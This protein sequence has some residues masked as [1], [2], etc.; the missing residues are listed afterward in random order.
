MQGDQVSVHLFPCKHV[1]TSIQSFTCSHT[2]V[3]PYSHASVPIH[4]ISIHPQSCTFS[5]TYDIYSQSCICS[6]TCVYLYSH[7][8]VPIKI[9][10]PIVMHLFPYIC[11]PIQSC[12]YSHASIHPYS[13]L[14]VPTTHIQSCTCTCFCTSIHAPVPIHLYTHTV[15]HLIYS[16]LYQD[17]AASRH[18]KT[19]T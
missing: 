13:L 11:T 8:S 2:C 19:V 17:V 10:T 18:F 3:H 14:P 7:A 12:T 1:Y 9:C 15:M 6:H 16:V 4:M 5:H